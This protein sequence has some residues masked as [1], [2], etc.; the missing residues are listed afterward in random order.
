MAE[1]AKDYLCPVCEGTGL[2]KNVP[3][4]VAQVCPECNGSPTVKPKK[5]N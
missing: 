3:L 1:R 5:E 2:E 4:D